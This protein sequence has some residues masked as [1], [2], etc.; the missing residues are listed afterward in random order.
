MHLNGL[1]AAYT[2]ESGGIRTMIYPLEGWLE[3][4]PFVLAHE[5]HH[6]ALYAVK[7][8]FHRTF[9]GGVM[10]EGL[11]DDFASRL[12]PDTRFSW[13]EPSFPL[14]E[15]QEADAYRY[16]Q[17]RLDQTENRVTQELY[18]F[19]RLPYDMPIYTGR[20]IV[21]R[22]VYGF[23]SSHP[24]S[25]SDLI[26]LAPKVIVQSSAYQPGLASR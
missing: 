8:D 26:T 3:K 17:G 6:A 21:Y 25:V 4:L 13:M 22:L 23:V 15:A 19:G 11:A 14:A 12:F 9:I 18:L 20:A 7:G 1:S 24:I 10:A 2:W 16:L 5:Y